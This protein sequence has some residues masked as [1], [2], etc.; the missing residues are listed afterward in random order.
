MIAT[1]VASRF[2]D[3]GESEIHSTED[4]ELKIHLKCNIDSVY[5]A[6]DLVETID[7]I[8]STSLSVTGDSR[9][10]LWII[11]ISLEEIEVIPPYLENDWTKRY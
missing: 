6:E 1:E 8:P 2:D 11:G 10:S 3:Y 4:G 5:E 9:N 7:N